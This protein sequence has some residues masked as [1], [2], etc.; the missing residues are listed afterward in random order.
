MR[1]GSE[2]TFFQRRHTKGQQVQE[3]VLNIT[4]HQENAIK[5]TIKYHLTPVRMV[6]TKKKTRK[7]NVGKNL[8]RKESP[9]VLL[10]CVCVCVCVLVA[11]Q[12]PTLCNPTE[13]S[14]PDSF[15]HVILQVRIL[16][17]V[18][19]PFFRGYCQPRDQTLVSCTT[20]RFF[21]I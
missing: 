7:T 3:K 13:Y 10:V 21:T 2:Q 4:N 20:S 14:W 5:I 19:I 17:W 11:Q 12:C 6:I 18:T 8:W 15:V 1:R 9:Y 16:D